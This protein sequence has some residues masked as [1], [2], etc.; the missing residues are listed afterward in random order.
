MSGAVENAMAGPGGEDSGLAWRQAYE[1]PF[2]LLG[3]KWFKADDPVYCRLPVRPPVSIR[4]PVISLAHNTAGGQVRFRTNSRRVVLRAH[5]AG[6][7]NMDHMARTGQD[8]FDL[9]VGKAGQE[10]FVAVTRISGPEIKATLFH[11]GTRA[12]RDFRINFPLY[13]GV[14]TVEIGL[15][16]DAQVETPAP[17]ESPGCIVIYGTSITQGGCSARPGMAY[18]NIL[19]RDL[20]REVVNLGFSGNGMGEIE[21]AQLINAIPGKD[22]VV[23][24]YEANANEGVRKTM[25]PFVDTLRTA[26]PRL[27]ILVVSKVRYAEETMDPKA[28]ERREGLRRFQREFV[29]A[30]RDAGDDRIFFVDGATLLGDNWWECSVDGHHQTTLGFERMA[31]VLGPAIE[32]I[33][34]DVRFAE[35]ANSVVKLW[36]HGNPDGWNDPTPEETERGADNITRLRHINTPEIL[37]YRPDRHRANGIGILICPGGG[38]HILAIDHEGHDIARRCSRA[39]FTAFVLKYRLPRPGT[40]EVRYAPGLQDAQRALSLIHSRAVE[41]GIEKLGIMGFSAGAH[42]S[43]VTATHSKKRAYS[44]TDPVDKLECRPDFVGLIYPAYL[45]RDRTTGELAEEVR[46]PRN[47]PPVF[48]AQAEDDANYIHSSILFY[49][50]LLDR[51][52]PAEMHIYAKGGHGFGLRIPNRPAGGWID[53]FLAWMERQ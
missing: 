4:K 38:Y 2:Q 22:M 16:I 53:L 3:F 19:S 32:N 23:L 11:N 35:S 31:K 29:E 45:V 51:G 17:F 27:P 5:L 12:M 14:R 8:G 21:L 26:T 20:N 39:G 52:I 34:L 46:I 49:R 33:L 25:G 24:D 13:C 42:L 1:A 40:D 44:P 30:R 7:G 50:A 10:R 6:F 48:L 43:A 15:E 41:W 18:S 37:V 9:Y 28:L 36:P 47:M